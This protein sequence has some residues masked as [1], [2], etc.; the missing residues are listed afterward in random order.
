MPLLRKLLLPLACVCLV[1]LT[2]C[3]VAS[4]QPDATSTP[5][6]PAFSKSAQ[7]QNQEAMPELGAFAYEDLN[8]SLDLGHSEDLGE[9]SLLDE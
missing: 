1:A 8:S 9:S 5:A 3:G 6:S 7:E 2:S 4:T